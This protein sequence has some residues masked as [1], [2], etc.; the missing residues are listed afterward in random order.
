MNLPECERGREVVEGVSHAVGEAAHN[1]ERHREKQR[2]EILLSC[3]CHGS[4]HKKAATDSEDSATD[5]SCTEAELNDILRRSL[6][7]H[8]RDA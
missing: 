6:D 5:S 8:R 2:Q 1:E 3:K 7:V 4:C